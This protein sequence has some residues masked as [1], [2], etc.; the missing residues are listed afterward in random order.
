MSSQ[1]SHVNRKGIGELVGRA[2]A[3]AEAFDSAV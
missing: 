1:Y 2:L 3:R